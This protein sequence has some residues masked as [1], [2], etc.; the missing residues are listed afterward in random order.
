MPLLLN[1]VV[2]S[3]LSGTERRGSRFQKAEAGLC[4]GTR[5]TES[6]R[7]YYVG[8]FG[9]ESIWQ[10]GQSL[11][12]QNF[13]SDCEDRVTTER[14]KGEEGGDG[15]EQRQCKEIVPTCPLPLGLMSSVSPPWM[16]EAASERIQPWPVSW[17]KLNAIDR[18]IE[19]V[20]HSISN[21]PGVSFAFRD[22]ESSS[23][24]ASL[25]FQRI[26]QDIGTGRA[27]SSERA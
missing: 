27:V 9:R 2:P 21:P 13:S 4:K 24:L 26:A 3:G 18:F 19:R 17:I 14:S 22:T 25:D 12:G 5:G 15:R 6:A 10:I 8:S 1:N 7:R 16:V 23:D 20:D 11:R